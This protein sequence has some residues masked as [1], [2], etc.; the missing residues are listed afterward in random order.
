[1]YQE[2]LEAIK[3]RHNIFITGAAGTGKSYTLKS[4]QEDFPEMAVTAS[5]GAAAVNIG[6]ITI[7]SYSGI[8][9][10]DRPAE[11]IEK[12]MKDQTRD[13]IKSCDMLA[14]DEISMI[15]GDLLELLNEVFKYVRHSDQPFGGVQLIVIGDFLQ[16]PPVSKDEQVPFAF[17]SYAWKEADFKT[18]HLT[19]VYRQDDQEFCRI[20]ADIR[21]G[22]VVD[23][24]I[25]SLVDKDEPKENGYVNLFA[26]NRLSNAYNLENLREIKSPNVFIQGHDFGEEKYK[27]ILDKHC[28]AP[29]E[30]FLKVGARVM[31][32][33]NLDQ[34]AGLI[35]GSMGYVVDICKQARAVRVKFDNGITTDIHTETVTQIT[36]DQEVVAHREQVPLRLAW[37]ISIHKSQGMTLDR[38]RIDMSGIFEYG[39]VYVALS[40]AKTMQNLYIKNLNKSSIRAHP[41]AVEFINENCN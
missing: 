10:G 38:V 23:E 3:S 7:H 9:I 40:R 33:L 25:R 26:L 2:I 34:E 11:V 29:K 28:L 27:A 36:V 4:L 22:K 35:N 20:L 1:M 19:K 31:L 13:R 37:A 5:T 39:Q 30:L 24:D 18:F 17:E 15:N 32:L 14:I 16:L 6:G 21:K 12:Y 41:K 8:G